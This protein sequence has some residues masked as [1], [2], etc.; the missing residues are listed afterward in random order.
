MGNEVRVMHHGRRQAGCVG[1]RADRTLN[2]NSALHPSLIKRSVVA[3]CVNQSGDADSLPPGVYVLPD[4]CRPAGGW[5]DP[6]RVLLCGARRWYSRSIGGQGRGRG[7]G[8]EGVV[9]AATPASRVASPVG[10]Y[11]RP[12]GRVRETGYCWTETGVRLLQGSL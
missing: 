8:P 6:A 7:R 10:R 2:L 3:V 11:R 12:G 1:E 5:E 9:Q 4:L